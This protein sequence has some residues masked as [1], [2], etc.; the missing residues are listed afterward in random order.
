VKKRDS[1]FAASTGPDATLAVEFVPESDPAH[2]IVMAILRVVPASRWAFARLRPDGALAGLLLDSPGSGEEMSHLRN[3][4]D[5]Q[6]EQAKTGARIAA[7]LGPL[8]DF[9]SG[10]T[11]L[12]ADA[13]ASFGI[14]T[15]LR[16]SE[17]GPF[18]SSEI[19]V[20]TLSLDATSERLSA[21]RL[22][23]PEAGR[24]AASDAEGRADDAD[25]AGESFYVLDK[26]LQIVLAWSA[27]DQR[28][29][30]LTGLRTRLADRLPAVLE[31]TVRELV[32]SWRS[33]ADTQETGVAHPVPF[34]VVRTRP[35][36]GPAGLFIGVRID[37]FQPPHSLT[38]PA[39]RFHISARELQVLALLLDG[40]KLNE[41]GRKLHITASTIQDHIKSMVDKTGSRNRTELIAR[42]LGWESMPE[43]RQA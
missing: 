4:L 8:G 30:A 12:F 35:M 3:E 42:V 36:S 20:L 13:H 6:R 26:D 34:L 32:A 31:E 9:E 17:L 23:S 5:L 38:G 24:Y 29:V 40:A 14:L 43:E 18:T 11:L 7:T 22:N 25:A 41:I 10:I 39:E 16:T 15:L 2:P 21:L 19:S 37:R 33:D 27:E 1:A 28:R